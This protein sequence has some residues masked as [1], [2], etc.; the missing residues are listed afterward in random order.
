MTEKISPISHPLIDNYSRIIKNL[1]GRGRNNY[2][3]YLINPLS[4]W[5]SKV[6]VEPMEK[7]LSMINEAEEKK[8]QKLPLLYKMTIIKSIAPEQLD[9]SIPGNISINFLKSMKYSPKISASDEAIEFINILRKPFKEYSDKEF[10]RMNKKFEE[11]IK[12]AD[13]I[14]VEKLVNLKESDELENKKNE[15]LSLRAISDIEKIMKSNDTNEA[16]RAIISY[17]LKFS[18]TSNPN[19]HLAINRIFENDIKFKKEIMNSTAIIIYHEILNAIKNKKLDKAIKFIGKYTVLFRG[20]PET[21]N[22][23]EVDTFE[24]KFFQI[25][26]HR[27]LW[28]SI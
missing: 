7:L 14:Q 13:D 3:Y 11:E 1:A 18:N 23:F 24:K 5:S 9:L 6:P 12:T 8:S 21:P 26:E 4:K 16:K 10:I 25:I 2:Q 15:E 28:D 20:N 27:N 17:L 19:M 22:Y